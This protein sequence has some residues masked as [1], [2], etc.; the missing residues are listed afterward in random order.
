MNYT[1]DSSIVERLF[2]IASQIKDH[3]NSTR[4]HSVSFSTIKDGDGINRV[5]IDTT[6]ELWSSFFDRSTHVF[7]KALFGLNPYKNLVSSTVERKGSINKNLFT[8][9]EHTHA[10]LLDFTLPEIVNDDDEIPVLWKKVIQVECI[11]YT[12]LKLYFF[13]EVLTEKNRDSSFPIGKYVHLF[14][15]VRL[16]TSGPIHILAKTMVYTHSHLT[17]TSL[18][19]GEKC[20]VCYEHGRNSHSCITK[21]CG[22][23]FHLACDMKVQ[24]PEC[25]CCRFLD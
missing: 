22:H 18:P 23:Q 25:P 5:I 15:F 14:D 21:R 19:R 7:Y 8:V 4:P 24:S 20:S 16:H 12:F 1:M 2:L 6:D 17:I 13:A 11:L 9:Y 10:D 3:K